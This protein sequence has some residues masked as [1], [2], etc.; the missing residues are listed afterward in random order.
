MDRLPEALQGACAEQEQQQ[1][2]DPSASGVPTASARASCATRSSH[3]TTP[4]R[5]HAAPEPRSDLGLPSS[6]RPYHTQAAWDM[7]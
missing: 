7:N 6:R 1:G 3:I 2:Q 4:S 5:R